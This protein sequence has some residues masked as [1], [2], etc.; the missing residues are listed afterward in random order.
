[1]NKRLLRGFLDHGTRTA[2]DLLLDIGPPLF[3]SEDFKAGVQSVIE[4]GAKDFR[5]RVSFR[6]S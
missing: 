5:G 1:V 6:G 3:D 4:H 2:D